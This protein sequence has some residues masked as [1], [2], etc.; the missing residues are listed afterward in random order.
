M[1]LLDNNQWCMNVNL[2]LKEQFSQKWKL[3]HYLRTPMQMKHLTRWW[4]N[5]HF[6]VN[7]FFKLLRPSRDL[8]ICPDQITL[9]WIG[10]CLHLFWLPGAGDVQSLLAQLLL[11][12]SLP[13]DPSIIRDPGVRLWLCLWAMPWRHSGH[14][15]QHTEVWIPIRS[16]NVLHIE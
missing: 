7:W 12:V 10:N 16:Q 8:L 15:H 6:W 4:L 1:I 9:K 3:C 14:F 2:I 11:P 13:S 5:F